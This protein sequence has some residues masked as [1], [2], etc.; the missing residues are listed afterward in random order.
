MHFRLLTDDFLRVLREDGKADPNVWAIGDAARMESLALPAT[1]QGEYMFVHAPCK[2][3]T[4]R[5]DYI[6]TGTNTHAV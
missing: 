6:H 1:A 5:G 2:I 3:P 4:Q